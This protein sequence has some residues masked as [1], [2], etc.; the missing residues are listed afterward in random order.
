MAAKSAAKLGAAALEAVV[1]KNPRPL[2]KAAA[3]VVYDATKGASTGSRRVLTFKASMVLNFR[4]QVQH[5][6]VSGST[7]FD[8]LSPLMSNGTSL[9]L[10]PI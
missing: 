6:N 4:R 7:A 8:D 5:V 1:T 2:G 9:H 3:E 10:L